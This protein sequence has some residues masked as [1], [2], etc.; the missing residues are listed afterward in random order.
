[1]VEGPGGIDLVPSER[2]LAEFE[3][4]SERLLE[5][6]RRLRVALEGAEQNYDWVLIDCPPR[7]EGVLCANALFACTTAMLVVE[8]GAFALQG[9]LQVQHVLAEV[10]ENQGRDFDVRVVGTMFD[11]RTKFAREL[12]V[13][14]HARF[15]DDMLDTVI[16]TS[17]R[18]REAPALGLPV[19]VLDPSCRAATDFS[20]LAEELITSLSSE[21]DITPLARPKISTP[22][23]RSSA[24][25]PAADASATRTRS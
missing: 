5:P 18:L 23:S 6:E 11:R 13:A 21:D 15:G 16:R 9:A 7:A 2:R 17:V 20:A 24:P 12:L 4:V 22:L 10:A 14:L 3:E 19:H 1:M 8:T 25:N